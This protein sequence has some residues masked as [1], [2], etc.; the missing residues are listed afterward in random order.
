MFYWF[1]TMND[2]CILNVV[3]YLA[4]F[5][6]NFKKPIDN[7]CMSCPNAHFIHTYVTVQAHEVGSPHIEYTV[8][9]S[10]NTANYLLMGTKPSV[11]I[12]KLCC[13][14]IPISMS[15]GRSHGFA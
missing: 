9:M 13:V 6:V 7:E 11:P 8:A 12:H 4:F 3:G 15:K 1:K 10:L 2:D 5:I 14:H